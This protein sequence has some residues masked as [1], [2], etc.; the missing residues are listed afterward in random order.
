MSL[1]YIYDKLV[2][3]IIYQW[4]K[5]TSS[6]KIVAESKATDRLCFSAATKTD[7]IDG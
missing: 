4:A 6:F 1:L 2:Y 3:D 7:K 5:T